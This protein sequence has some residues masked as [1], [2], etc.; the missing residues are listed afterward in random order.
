MSEADATR[1]AGW[2]VTSPLGRASV[3]FGR[4]VHAL[5]GVP[6]DRLSLEEATQR[7]RQ[8][9]L[10]R[11]PLFF[12][13]PNVNFVVTACRDAAFRQSVLASDLSVVDGMPLV[14]LARWLGIPL[15]ERVA[16]ADLFERLR[17]SPSPRPLRVY[18]F[19]GPQGVAETASAKVGG[20]GR[21]T[22]GVGGQSPGF[23]PL[24]VLSSPDRLEAINRAQPDLL[25]VALGAL[26]GQAWIMRNRASLVGAPVVSHLGAVVNFVA[27][28]VRR[29][30]PWVSRTGLE[31]LWRIF[32]EPSLWRRYLGDA[33]A[34]VGLVRRHVLPV[35]AYQHA[36]AHDP[37]RAVAGRWSVRQAGT[38]VTLDLEG[39][40]RPPYI[41]GLRDALS[42][43]ARLAGDLTV[44][45]GH[46]TILDARGFGLLLLLQGWCRQVDAR[47][48]VVAEDPALAQALAAQGLGADLP[49]KRA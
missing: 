45:F 31:W 4:D 24:E 33:W 18:F 6:F 36:A 5:L 46:G 39:D 30:P 38:S 26:K 32:Q 43:A 35:R 25:L 27:G 15:D 16:G 17:G 23:H 47:L 2:C 48:D 11:Q 9:C 12:S 40:W 22:V 8:A 34:M 21:S 44:H 14:W 10:A 19:G 42:A 29:A 20:P 13:T 37:V 49:F 7:V 3:D 28:T 41:D 1:R